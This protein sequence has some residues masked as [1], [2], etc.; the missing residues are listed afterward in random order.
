MAWN[1]IYTNFMDHGPSHY[2]HR[3]LKDIEND[4]ASAIG[5]DDEEDAVPLDAFQKADVP[6]EAFVAASKINDGQLDLAVQMFRERVLMLPQ[7]VRHYVWS[8]LLYEP[9]KTKSE[10]IKVYILRIH[11]RLTPLCLSYQLFHTAH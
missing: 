4:A 7:P 6:G 1:S 9:V 11:P 10:K 2:H 3:R 8:L 5:D